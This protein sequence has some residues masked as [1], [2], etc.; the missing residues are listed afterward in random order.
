M[1]HPSPPRS[2]MEPPI[3]ARLAHPGICL[4]HHGTSWPVIAHPANINIIRLAHPVNTLMPVLA[5]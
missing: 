1:E 2:S 5:I 3:L 4:A